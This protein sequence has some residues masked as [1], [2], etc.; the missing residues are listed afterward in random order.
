MKKIALI[1]FLLFCMSM[2]AMA[3]DLVFIEESDLAIIQIDPD[4]IRGFSHGGI[5]FIVVDEVVFPKG[6]VQQQIADTYS[7]EYPVVF[8]RNE[9]VFVVDANLYQITALHIAYAKLGTK[10][11][12]Y[13]DFDYGIDPDRFKEFPSQSSVGKIYQ[14]I[15]KTKK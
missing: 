13:K 9:L 15:I 12:K 3:S 11:V 14:Y 6:V 4:T 5:N 1:L 7:L 2:P 8:M 10:D